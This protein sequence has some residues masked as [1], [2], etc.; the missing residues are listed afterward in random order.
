M[1]VSYNKRGITQ[2]DTGVAGS[3]TISFLELFS[4]ATVVLTLTSLT[5]N[6]YLLPVRQDTEDDACKIK[7]DPLYSAATVLRVFSYVCSRSRVFIL[8]SR[9]SCS[10]SPHQVQPWT[11]GKSHHLRWSR[12]WLCVVFSF[13]FFSSFF[14]FLFSFARETREI[15]IIFADYAVSEVRERLRERSNEGTCSTL[16]TIFS[17]FSHRL[18]KDSSHVRGETARDWCNKSFVNS[19][20]S[21]ESFNH[22]T[23]ELIINNN[24]IRVRP[25]N[26][27]YSSF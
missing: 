9:S 23:Y 17:F 8:R 5:C 22:L 10:C 19:W 7:Y 21:L 12:S 3:R 25:E 24:E 20:R 15:W 18:R 16:C 2:G 27:I 13:L 4:H 14:F 6:C 11:G 1:R 26:D